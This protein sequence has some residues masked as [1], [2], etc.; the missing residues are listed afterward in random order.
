M[1]NAATNSVVTMRSQG[2]VSGSGGSF[3]PV[4]SRDGAVVAF[5]SYANDL[6][7]N[8]AYGLALDLF[9]RDLRNGVTTQ[10]SVN[11]SGGG[12][13]DGTSS[14]PSLSGDG[15]L[16][17]F[18][19]LAVNLTGSADANRVSDVFL[20][21]T[22]AGMTFLVSVAANGASAGNGASRNPQMTPDGRWIVFESVASNLV[23]DDINNGSDVFLRD[24]QG[25]ATVVVSVSATNDQAAAGASFS[26]SISADGNRI[27]F[28][29][30]ATEL[31]TDRANPLGDVYVRDLATRTTV[32]ASVGLNNVF[33]GNFQCFAPVISSNGSYVAFKA[34][35]DGQ[36]VLARFAFESGLTEIVSTNVIDRTAPEL[37]ANGR[38]VAYE[39]ETNAFVWDGE[40]LTNILVN[41]NKDGTGPANGR[42]QRPTLSSDGTTVAFLSDASNL[43]DAA[44]STPWAQVYVRDIANGV[45]RL[46]SVTRDG[47]SADC[48]GANNPRISPDSRQVA[49][50]TRDGNLV[51]NDLNQDYDV[52]VRDFTIGETRL[53]SSRAAGA[54][55]T[56][57]A[58]GIPP[59][60]DCVSAEGRF[61][62]FA[63]TSGAVSGTQTSK[64]SQVFVRDVLR[65]TNI[66]ASVAPDGRPGNATSFLPIISAN[67]STVAFVSAA[68]NLVAGDTNNATDV[69]VR[70][71]LSG[72]TYRGSTWAP[73]AAYLPPSSLSISDNGRS[74]AYMSGSRPYLRID[75]TETNVALPGYPGYGVRISPDGRWVTAGDGYYLV[76]NDLVT[77]A[78][79]S[80]RYSAPGNNRGLSLG[81]VLNRNSTAVAYQYVNVTGSFNSADP[82]RIFVYDLSAK[83]NAVVATHALKPSLSA[84]ARLLVYETTP[85]EGKRQVV[86]HDVASGATNVISRN[87]AGEP[88]NGDSIWPMISDD[89]RYVVFSS[90][91]SDLVSDDTNNCSDVFVRDLTLNITLL[92]SRGRGGGIGNNTSAQAVLGADGRTVL[93]MSFANDLVEN[94]LDNDRDIFALRLGSGDSDGDGLDDDWELAFFNTLSRNGDEDFDGDGQSDRSEFK[95]GTNP[96]DGT[97]VFRVLTLTRLSDGTTTLLWSSSPS[98]KY[99][100]QFK[101][102]LDD[103]IWTDLVANVIANGPTTSVADPAASTSPRRF[104]R[105]IL[106]P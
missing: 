49:F 21:D 97:S 35:G 18:E 11:A 25:N 40:L 73:S 92:V 74:I 26:P 75:G 17:A 45:T 68:S 58:G 99:T 70:D 76:V 103:T 87:L 98:R 104:Y 46:A 50:E 94:D 8:R 100:I 55:S 91:A 86:L 1:S 77:G 65:G 10:I 89:G 9:T 84:D 69:F 6:V 57:E 24:V 27:A 63:S 43:V 71:L 60:R 33:A 96:A 101:D 42:S 38:F 47:T 59:R 51:T 82:N 72:T 80:T 78:T 53:V 34:T 52:F 2:C 79:A 54:V 22:I 95:A 23:T 5:L 12:G 16:V 88:G 19:S 4:F 7:P 31:V 48:Y 56:T 67:G 32:S 13:G 105:V 39:S 81:L 93:F 29:S 102:G 90:S 36:T 30:T 61:I 85:A 83:T 41:V 28:V 14:A 37:S 20:R 66:L 62:V 64:V 15:R 44:S 106:N 3:A